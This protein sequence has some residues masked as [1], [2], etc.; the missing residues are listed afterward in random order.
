M[1]YAEK[2]ATDFRTVDAAFIDELREHF[3]EAEIAELGLMI[4][5]YIA[6]GRLLVISG[7]AN[8]AC[9]IYVPDA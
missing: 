5:Q 4:G 2:L 6:I 9:E 3:S 1:R 7:G 8:L